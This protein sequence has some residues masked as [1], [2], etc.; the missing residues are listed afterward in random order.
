LTNCTWSAVLAA[1]L[2]FP[3]RRQTPLN[4]Y[5]GHLRNGVEPSDALVKVLEALQVGG[6]GEELPIW[7]YIWSL[8]NNITCC[9]VG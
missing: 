1:V 8:Y 4:I 2:Q 5:V 9:A 3:M 7:C 6:V